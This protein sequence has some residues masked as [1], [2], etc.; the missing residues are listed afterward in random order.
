MFTS[1]GALGALLVMLMLAHP[2][3]ANGASNGET[4]P[5]RRVQA[6]L[7][8]L[9]EATWIAQGDGRRILYVFVDPNCPYCQLLYENLQPLIKPHGLQLRWVPVA[10]LGPTSV[11][12]AAAILEAKDPLAALDY[13]EKHY[14]RETHQGGIAETIASAES[15]SRL[16][17]NADLL[18][19]VGV[20]VVPTTVFRSTSG[21]ALV[22]QG[23]L[24]PTA[25]RKIVERVAER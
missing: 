14:N 9:P 17:R 16:R 19:R 7:A 1:K 21:E 5:S 12:K 8:A 4:N 22:I 25:L 6:V 18:D 11:G 20:P 13:N 23:A 24:S 10:I 3:L 2:L 15:E